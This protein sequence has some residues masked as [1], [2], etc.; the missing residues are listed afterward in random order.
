MNTQMFRKQL[1]ILVGVDGSPGTRAAITWAAR[2]AVMRNVPLTLVH[3]AAKAGR[4]A[5]LSAELGVRSDD[6]LEKDRSD[7]VIE[8][9]QKIA[10]EATSSSRPPQ[11]NTDAPCAATVPA[12]VDL[13]KLADMVVVG[14]RSPESLPHGLLRSVSYHLIRHAHCPV[15]VINAGADL[16]S[17][18]PHAPVLAGVDGSPISELATSVAFDEA[19]RRGVELVALHAWFHPDRLDFGHIHQ[20]PVDWASFEAREQ[21]VLAERL[22]GWQ[23]LYPDVV[24]RK[25]VVS[26]RPT[27]QLLKQAQTAQLLVIGSRGR[28]P[29]TSALLSSASYTV[30]D[31]AQIPVIVA[32]PPDQHGIVFGSQYGRSESLRETSFRQRH[33]A[34][35]S[36]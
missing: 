11:M 31:A 23:E 14:H 12:L 9:A 30:I 5:G 24:V 21:E 29:A 25:V 2:D 15:A 13:S 16:E 26:D 22:S 4:D 32:R 27:Y 17:R 36:T 33:Y 18:Q 8:E 28:G 1:G 6:W 35:C 10:V 34:A 19:S 20:A 3:V 7:R